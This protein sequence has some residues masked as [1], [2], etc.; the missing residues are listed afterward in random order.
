MK[1]PRQSPAS[2]SRAA[3]RAFR[4]SCR[5]WKRPVFSRSRIV[6]EFTPGPVLDVTT[7]FPDGLTI[8]PKA[9]G[10]VAYSSPSG[11]IT[12]P[13]GKIGAPPRRR[14]GRMPAGA[15]R[16]CGFVAPASKNRIS[17]ERVGRLRQWAGTSSSYKDATGR[18]GGLFV[19]SDGHR[20][21]EF[22]KNHTVFANAYF[23]FRARSIGGPVKNC[24]KPI[25]QYL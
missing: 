15:E 21:S 18:P 1:T 17:V 7:V 25:L 13:P 9:P 24:T 16:D 19:V 5:A 20:R 14:A 4:M 8:R 23:T 2:N 3:S 11:T 10:P 22:V 6:R 12:R